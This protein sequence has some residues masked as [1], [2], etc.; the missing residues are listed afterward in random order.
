MILEVGV[1]RG[2]TLISLVA[3]L[4]RSKKQFVAIGVDVLIQEQV[5]IVAR[6]LDLLPEQQMFLLQQ[7]S[8]ET[9]PK[10]I[11]QGMKFDLIL[12][13]GDH[14]YHTVSN[15]LLHLEA[16]TH[17]HSLVVIDDY[18]GRWADRDL[19]YAQRPD[20]KD[21]KGVTEP[22]SGEKHGV[23]LAVDEYLTAHPV[24]KTAKPISGEPILLTRANT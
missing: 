4:A 14:N 1:D 16:L 15:E 13:D 17:P 22:V 6:N 11:E 12:I 8:L 3:F 18:E 7:N 9:L 21:V 10:L 24:W 5:A 19:W 20:Y 23:K 2:V